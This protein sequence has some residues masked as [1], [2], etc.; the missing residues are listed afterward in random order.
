MY[1]K[2]KRFLKLS[3]FPCYTY[4]SKLELYN[5]LLLKV[6]STK[7]VLLSVE[8]VDEKRNSKE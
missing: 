8:I 2:Y 4:I 7:Q 6:R 1:L 3:S 5:R